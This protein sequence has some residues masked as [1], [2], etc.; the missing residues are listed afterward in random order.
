MHVISEYQAS[1]GS[2]GCAVSLQDCLGLGCKGCGRKEK[3]KSS[4]AYAVLALKPSS[5]ANGSWCREIGS[6]VNAGITPNALAM[7]ETKRSLA[8]IGH[9]EKPT[10]R[11]YRG[12]VNIPDSRLLSC[13]KLSSRSEFCN[14]STKFPRNATSSL[15]R[16]STHLHIYT[17]VVVFAKLIARSRTHP[18]TL[19]PGA[20][21][22]LVGEPEAR[23]IIP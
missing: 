7:A 14:A 1:S 8:N 22:I 12:T 20:E 9:M 18:L 13:P 2:E 6:N 16:A 23:M 15:R 21:R 10:W 4:A 11:R 17:S 3:S 5:F 19:L